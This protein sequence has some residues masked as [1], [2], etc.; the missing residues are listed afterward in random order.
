[1][2]RLLYDVSRWHLFLH[3][4]SRGL[5]QAAPEDAARRMLEDELF[6]RL[7]AGAAGPCQTEGTPADEVQWAKR[8]HET[9]DAL[10][11]FARLASECRGDE[12]AASTAV[13]S[14]LDELGE[15]LARPEPDDQRRLRLGLSRGCFRASDAVS[16]QR[17]VHEGLANIDGFGTERG[18]QGAPDDGTAAGKLAARLRQDPRLRELGLLAGRFKRI[19]AGKRRQRVAHGAEEVVS[20]GQGADLERLLPAELAR[21]THP[22]HRLAFFR[23][24]L[25]RQT[26]QYELSGREPLGRGPLVVCLDKSDSMSGEKD[27]FAVAAAI[28]LHDLA[29]EGRRPY[30]LI[31]FDSTVRQVSQTHAG[32]MLPSSAL[33]VPCSGGTDITAA[34]ENGLDVIKDSQRLLRAD[35]VLITDGQS[36]IERAPDLRQRAAE[37][38]VNIL[39]LGIGVPTESLMPWCDDAKLVRSVETLDDEV[40]HALGEV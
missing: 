10:P 14:L 6:E 4:D 26:L 37:L 28:A 2:K 16:E 24:F 5:P 30:A 23:D 11:A 29:N 32:E 22:V 34:I 3:R 17:E 18:A 1:M 7:Y 13:E 39:G 33:F 21:L 12:N 27:L 8:V 25:E 40:V 35:I 9:C 19:L 36:S 31:S 20:I 38:G 15:A